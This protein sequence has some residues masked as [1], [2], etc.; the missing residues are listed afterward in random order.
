MGYD[1]IA[2]KVGMSPRGV[3]KAIEKLIAAGIVEKV[4][5]GK[6]VQYDGGPMLMPNEYKVVYPGAQ[7]NTIKVKFNLS[8]LDDFQGFYYQTLVETC[9]IKML[10]KYLTANEIKICK[11]VS[12]E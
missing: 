1:R 5:Q 3:F 8:K 7:D 11:A 9:G 10:K 12:A 4:S 6:L 2:E